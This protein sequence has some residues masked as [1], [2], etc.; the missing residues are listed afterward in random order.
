VSLLRV[1]VRLLGRSLYRV[2]RPLRARPQLIPFANP[3]RPTPTAVSCRAPAAAAAATATTA[4]AAAAAE[5]SRSLPFFLS[6]S[7]SVFLRRL[8]E[9]EDAAAKRRRRSSRCVTRA[10]RI[11]VPVCVTVCVPLRCAASNV[12]EDPPKSLLSLSLS[13]F[14]SLSLPARDS[15]RLRVLRLSSASP[16]LTIRDAEHLAYLLPGIVEPQEHCYAPLPC[17][18]DRCVLSIAVSLSSHLRSSP[19]ADRCPAEAAASRRLP[20]YLPASL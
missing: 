3:S 4:A 6:P 14:L 12:V 10:A 7:P 2:Y 13:L 15:R 19:G 11:R 5:R 20:A 9:E 16:S 1:V 17:V 18:Y 8:E